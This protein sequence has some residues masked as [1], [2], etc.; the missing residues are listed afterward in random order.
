MLKL[1]RA[2]AEKDKQIKYLDMVRKVVY[3]WDVNSTIIVPVVVL[4]NGFLF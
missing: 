2:K 4:A 1:L 3:M